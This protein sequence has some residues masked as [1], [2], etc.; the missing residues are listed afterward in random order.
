[1]AIFGRP[2]SVTTL[3][4]KIKDHE[5]HSTQELLSWLDRID[6]EH[7]L[8]PKQVVWM[9]G[10]PHR[11]VREFGKLK[12]IRMEERGIVELLLRELSGKPGSIRMEIAN[13]AT[14]IDP[15]QV[16]KNLGRMLH[17]NQIDQRMS[18]LDLIAV[19]P[20]WR[21]Y[22]GHLKA[23]L[24]DPDTVVRQKVVEIL[25]REPED[26]TIKL[27]LRNL[28]FDEDATIRRRVIGAL[29]EH[30]DP[31]LVEPFLERLPY[32]AT[33]EQTV[34]VRALTTMARNPEA[35]L[36]DRLLPMLADE[37][38]HVRE[39]AIRL[40]RE[41]PNRTQVIRAYL[42]YSKGLAYWLR[43]RSYKTFLRISRDILDPLVELMGDVD[44]EIKVGAMLLASDSNDQRVVPGLRKVLKDQ[45]QDW[46]VRVI[47]AENLARFPSPE[48]Q[49]D[50]I[51]EIDNPDLRHAIVAAL[52]QIKSGRSVPPLVQCLADPQVSVRMA[53]L[54]ALSGLRFPEVADMV[55]QTAVNDPEQ[56]VR[57]KA[58]LV[59]E[60]LGAAGSQRLEA[61]RDVLNLQ[62]EESQEELELEQE[63]EMENPKL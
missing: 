59:L 30:P 17:S 57:E 9:I 5:Y 28:V 2:E 8:R 63:L 13:L 25:C 12:L 19:H 40:L 56:Q 3:L 61:V 46:W 52:G 31:D 36:E 6:T 38:Q 26:I 32:E 7:E 44:P 53:V 43:E 23:A 11:E 10:H 1:M 4:K 39:A 58:L 16:Y 37:N 55:G 24:K 49:N 50:L 34:I 27:I 62:A 18:A 33:R 60:Q 41:I 45:T 20:E 21:E 47:A 15:Q 29:A 14:E 42:H 35:K 54:D 51:K 22:L 48:V